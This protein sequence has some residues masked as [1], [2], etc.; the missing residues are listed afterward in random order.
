MKSLFI[1]MRIVHWIGILLLVLNALLLTENLL[2]TIIQ[3][4]I[5]AVVL[6]HDLDEKRWGVDTIAQVS[7]YLENISQKDLSHACD[8]DARYNAEFAQLLTVV[9][10]LRNEISAVLKEIKTNSQTSLDHAGQV[11][12]MADNV[13]KLT[14]NSNNLVLQGSEKLIELDQL[15]TVLSSSTTD[16]HN[17]INHINS[18]L[19]EVQQNFTSLEKLLHDYTLNNTELEQDLDRLNDSADKVRGVLTVVA[20]IADQTNLLALNAAIEAARAGEQGRGFAVVADEVRGLAARTQKSLSEIDQIVGEITQATNQATGQM[21]RQI[22]RLDEMQSGMDKTVDIIQQTTTEGSSTLELVV[23]TSQLAH[24]LQHMST[25]MTEIINL[26]SQ[27]SNSNH[28]TITHI[29]HR[30]HE[31]HTMEDAISTSIAKFTL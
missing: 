1:R 9:D 4:I 19:Q 21:N 17:N 12:E 2:S 31:Q 15:A 6:I 27:H 11:A 25:S 28:Q 29:T 22:K 16:S 5:A 3:L 24:N 23:Q 26:I 8:V 10:N 13:L 18:N 7:H 14:A 30:I 20:G